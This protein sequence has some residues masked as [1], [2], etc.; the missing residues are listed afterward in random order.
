[1]SE[2]S[3]A[4]NKNVKTVK[5]HNV[6]NK[7]KTSWLGS[8]GKA[9]TEPKFNLAQNSESREIDRQ[10]HKF[11]NLS[12]KENLADNVLSRVGKNSI[13]TSDVWKDCC[14]KTVFPFSKGGVS[15]SYSNSTY[16]E[17]ADENKK[18]KM[19]DARAYIPPMKIKSKDKSLTINWSENFESYG[20][21]SSLV[22]YR[23]K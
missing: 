16:S 5:E 7:K 23:I 17:K 21:A 12:L 9:S 20:L 13:S 19:S 4:P 10:Q 6:P 8:N 18:P 3:D 14:I 1:M 2:A 11:S 15:T 22:F